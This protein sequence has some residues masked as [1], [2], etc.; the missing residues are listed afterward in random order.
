VGRPYNQARGRRELKG[1][2]QWSH[3]LRLSAPLSLM[4][5]YLAGMPHIAATAQAG[6]LDIDMNDRRGVGG[7]GRNVISWPTCHGGAN[8]SWRREGRFIKAEVEGRTW[9]LDVNIA[10]SAGKGGVGRN[11]IAWPDC[12]GGANQSWH[13]EDTSYKVFLNG[14]TYCLDVDVETR[15]GAGGRGRNV[16]VWPSCHGGGNQR[17][18]IE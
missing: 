7:Q 3:R 4:L 9:C 13:R 6:C 8:Q 14:R 10:V 11:V 2:S 15:A 12:H 18:E 17:W 5:I 1:I 16:I